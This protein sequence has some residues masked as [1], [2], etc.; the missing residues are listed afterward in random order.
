MN[1]LIDASLPRAVATLLRSAGHGALD[2]R[3][4]G[5]TTASDDK[6]AARAAADRS[7]IMTAD[8][9]FADVRLYPPAEYAGIIVIS[10]PNHATT[11]DVL[12]LVGSFLAHSELFDQVPGRLVIVQRDRIRLRPP[13]EPPAK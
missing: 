8:F 12:E 7:A 2:V 9:D 6:I 11:T 3:D 4:I 13:L 10:R 5:L 1:F